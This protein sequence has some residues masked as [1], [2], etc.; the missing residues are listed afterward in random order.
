[1]FCVCWKNKGSQLNISSTNKSK[2]PTARS[3]NRDLSKCPATDW[4]TLW[5]EV[6]T[7]QITLRC[8]LSWYSSAS[9]SSSVSIALSS[10]TRDMLLCERERPLDVRRNDSIMLCSHVTDRGSC[11]WTSGS[12]IRRPCCGSVGIVAVA[13]T[14]QKHA[15]QSTL[16]VKNHNYVSIFTHVMLF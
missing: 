11:R 9:S 13:C 3:T 1:M 2:H 4:Q 5:M 14:T 10:G 6:S 12:D 15:I 16:I 8:Y 7:V